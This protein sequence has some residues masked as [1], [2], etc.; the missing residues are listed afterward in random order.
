[1]LYVLLGSLAL[2]AVAMVGLLG[3]NG[4]NAPR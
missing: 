4:S 3:W 1:V 2:L